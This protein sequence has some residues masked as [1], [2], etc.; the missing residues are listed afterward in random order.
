MI[1][2]STHFIIPITLTCIFGSIFE[3]DF[4]LF[5]HI[6]IPLSNM[7][8]TILINDFTITMFPI[9][10]HLSNILIPIL[11]YH[12]Y[13]SIY[14]I[15]IPLSF[16]FIIKSIY[17]F[18]IAFSFIVSKLAHICIPIILNIYQISLSILFTIFKP[19]LV[20]LSITP[21]FTITYLHISANPIHFSISL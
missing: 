14:S 1:S 4:S 7:F 17:I 16:I 15:I 21:I 18:S 6:I 10:F 13:I 11:I 9:S 8:V 3:N 12:F 19:S 5:T 20:I 2:I